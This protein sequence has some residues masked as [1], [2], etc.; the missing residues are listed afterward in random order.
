MSVYKLIYFHL[1]GRGEV[2]RTLFRLANQP[3]EDYRLPLDETWIPLKPQYPFHQLPVLQVTEPDK[4]TYRIA[5]SH[6][7]E[8]FLANRFGLF[9]KNDAERAQIDMIG[10]QIV[11]VFNPILMIYRKPDSAV[12]K[13]S[14]L[15]EALSEKVPA[16][17]KMIQN[18]LETN[19]NGRG[20]LVGDRLSLVDVQLI[21]FY[22]WLRAEKGQV[23]DK[24]PALKRHDELVRSQPKIAEQSKQSAGV[25]LARLFPN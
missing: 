9:G 19:N 25:R 13:K 10:E 18:L 21:N 24:L 15:A 12:E 8:R 14:E 6:A 20:F 23:L 1:K 7:I 22:D 4:K 17:L 11:D 16:G 3:Y 2:T 5:Q